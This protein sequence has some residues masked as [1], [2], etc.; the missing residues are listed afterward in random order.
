VLI[1]NTN[2]Y[3]TSTQSNMK[4]LIELQITISAHPS[5]F[6]RVNGHSHIPLKSGLLISLLTNS[7]GDNPVRPSHSGTHPASGAIRSGG[8]EMVDDASCVT[9]ELDEGVKNADA[10]DAKSSRAAVAADVIFMINTRI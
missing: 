5:E 10:D 9:M 1:L 7:S 2:K 4:Y 8:D 3:F 6:H